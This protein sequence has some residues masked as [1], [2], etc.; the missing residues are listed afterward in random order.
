MN[1]KIAVNKVVKKWYES[2]IQEETDRNQKLKQLHDN[3][4]DL[5]N[6]RE[7]AKQKVRDNCALIGQSIQAESQELQS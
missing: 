3:L 4:L 5:K 7:Q 2:R 6:Q 1:F